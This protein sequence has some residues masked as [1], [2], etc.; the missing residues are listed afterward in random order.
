MGQKFAAYDDAGKI[1]AFFDAEINPPEQI[2]AQSIAIADD[3]W[4]EAVQSQA[5][6]VQ[7]GKLVAPEPP[8]TDVLLSD[9]KFSKL[10]QINTE[11]DKAA[12]Q[13]TAGYPVFEMQTW[14]AQQA[15]VLAWAADDTV[16]TPRID[17]MAAYRGI[18]RVAYLQKTLAKVQAFQRA[19][20]YLVGTRQKYSDQVTAA[21]TV[22]EVTAIAPEFNLPG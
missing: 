3:A 19:S 8:S 1:V 10:A 13:L 12:A 18:D 16:T 21:R 22:A 11:A 5:H 20:D 9:A 17:A 2:P 7:N 15:E 6:T 4:F 14:P